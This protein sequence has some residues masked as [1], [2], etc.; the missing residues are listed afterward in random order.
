[1]NGFE[2]R[3]ERK[4]ESIRQAALELFMEKGLRKVNIGEIA[5]K[6]DVS[7]VTIYN[8]FGSKEDLA[9]YVLFH[10]IEDQLA[11][12]EQVCEGSEPYLEKLEWMV[13]KKAKAYTSMNV[14]FLDSF[15]SSDPQIA[16]MM[17]DF[18]AKTIPLFIDFIEQGKELGYFN[19]QLSLETLMFY[20]NL[21]GNQAMQQLE[22]MPE[23]EQK[24]LVYKELLT[25]FFSGVSGERADELRSMLQSDKSD[26]NKKE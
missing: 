17:K 18:E 1:M 14:E 21:F 6:A 26:I 24:R 10:Y 20:I 7:Q 23:G 11:E 2:R 8:Y 22:Q 19:K 16:E 25:V 9:R 12:F 4:K 5:E 15:V 3:K 13:F